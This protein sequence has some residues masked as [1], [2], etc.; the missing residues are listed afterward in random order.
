[1]AGQGKKIHGK[2]QEMKGRVEEATGDLVGDE[3]MHLKG[4]RDRAVG[5]TREAAGE[6]AKTARGTKEELKGKA[7]QLKGK[8]R[9][10]M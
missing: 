2:A 9:K 1:M 7:E 6:A 8:T 3:S 5:K 4:A 10:N